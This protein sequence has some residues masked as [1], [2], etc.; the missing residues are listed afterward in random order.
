MLEVVPALQKL[1]YSMCP[2][3]MNEENFWRYV[4]GAQTV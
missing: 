3:K 2:T 1:R 4:H